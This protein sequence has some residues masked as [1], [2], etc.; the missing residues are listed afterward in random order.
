MW[1]ARFLPHM[2]HV[3][4]SPTNGNGPTQGQRKFL[5]RVGIE[6]TT[7]GLNHHCSTDRATR[8][9]G[10]RPWETEILKSPHFPPPAWV[11]KLHWFSRWRQ[12]Q[13]TVFKSIAI[14]IFS[15]YFANVRA[16]KIPQDQLKVLLSLL[17][18][19]RGGRW[20]RLRAKAAEDFVDDSP[21]EFKL[22]S[23]I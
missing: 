22:T 10:S 4:V 8:S 11:R 17:L 9:D 5:T 6:L 3:S 13:N 21:V 2:S 16:S 1:S 14:A 23:I 18:A 12:G 15:L 7:F 20:G 19:K